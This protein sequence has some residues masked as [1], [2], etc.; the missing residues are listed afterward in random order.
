MNV[1]QLLSPPT[2]DLTGA[3]RPALMW[4]RVSLLPIT[5]GSS[6]SLRLS[7]A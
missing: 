6:L 3:A 7:H 1:V 5:Q 4:V 2:I